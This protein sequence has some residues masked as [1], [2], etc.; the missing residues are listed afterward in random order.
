MTDRF[1]IPVNGPAGDAWTLNSELQ[2]Y[3]RYAGKTSKDRASIVWDKKDKTVLAV[4][5]EWNDSNKKT[6]SERGFATYHKGDYVKTTKLNNKYL[7]TSNQRP[8]PK[9][10]AGYSIRLSA[11]KEEFTGAIEKMPATAFVA[12][13]DDPS[14]TK[15]LLASMLYLRPVEV[16]GHG[17]VWSPQATASTLLVL[18][19][20]ILNEIVTYLRIADKASLLRTNWRL[21]DIVARLLYRRVSVS[22]RHGRALLKTIINSHENYGQYLKFMNYGIIQSP[23]S[24]ARE[25]KTPLY[26]GSLRTLILHGDVMFAQLARYRIVN[27]I[28]YGSP[29]KQGDFLYL[30]K[31]IT[32]GTD[33]GQSAQSRR[34]FQESNP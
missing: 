10:H 1:P 6:T 19:N 16:R 11:R 2:Q 5:I 12:A 18:P 34:I 3:H 15:P 32:G 28:C 27:S 29:L 21:H 25:V 30:I 7:D 17:Y 23:C 8:S 13:E 14:H 26:L 20:K 24:D 9:K 22:G 31:A 33:H 4:D